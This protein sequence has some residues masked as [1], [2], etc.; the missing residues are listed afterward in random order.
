MCLKERGWKEKKKKKKTVIERL[1]FLLHH[2]EVVFIIYKN[3]LTHKHFF[4]PYYSFSSDFIC[5]VFYLLQYSLINLSFPRHLM[6][7]YIYFY[8]MKNYFWSLKYEASSKPLLMI[9]KILS[10][11][12][13][14]RCFLFFF[15]FL[16]H[17]VSFNYP[18]LYLQQ[19]DLEKTQVNHLVW[20][21]KHGGLEI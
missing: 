17:D 3:P 18:W 15:F 10:L 1:F 12:C 13:I 5:H 19:H 20:S 9:I 21:Y 2:I 16:V 6:S 7:K 11:Q 14:C 4:Y 8:W